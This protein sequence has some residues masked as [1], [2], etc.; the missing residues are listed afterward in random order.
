MNVASSA[1]DTDDSDTPPPEG[2]RHTFVT[3]SG[4]HLDRAWFRGDLPDGQLKFT[5]EITSPVVRWSDVDSEGLLT[6]PAFVKLTFGNFM[7]PQAILTLQVNDVDDDAQDVCPEMDYVRIN[8]RQIFAPNEVTPA[9]LR[10]GHDQWNEWKVPVPITLLRFPIAGSSGGNPIPGINEVAIEVNAEC[11]DDGW[12]V[13][14]DWGSITLR[15]NLTTPIVFVHGWTGRIDTFDVFARQAIADGYQAFN[16]PDNDYLDRGVGTLEETT[17]KVRAL[18]EQALA[19]TGAE[20]VFI[21]A[22][23]RGGIFVRQALRKYEA[24]ASRVAVYLTIST[25]HHGVDGVDLF[26]LQKCAEFWDAGE[27]WRCVVT[28][29]SLTTGPMR[30]FNYGKDC[31]LKTWDLAELFETR[32]NY[33]SQLDNNREPLQALRDEFA[34]FESDAHA[35]APDAHVEIRRP[36]HEWLIVSGAKYYVIRYGCLFGGCLTVNLLTPINESSDE[37]L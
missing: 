25:S 32:T 33:A 20:K 17:P 26:G 34:S 16:I 2:N 8:G 21:V 1:N 28:A 14:V 15:P 10:G 36:G 35:L 23:S 12:A 27:Y 11:E 19:T 31:K 30:E 3:D 6:P 24:L 18:I 9:F 4:G 7:P 22:H 29:A 37:T 5:I 13:K